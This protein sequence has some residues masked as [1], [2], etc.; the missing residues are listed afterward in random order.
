MANGNVYSV[1]HN[2]NV[3]GDLINV[4][5]ATAEEVKDHMI[6]LAEVSDELFEAVISVK[7]A[8]LAKGVFSERSSNGS[9]SATPPTATTTAVSS[10][11]DG[12]KSCKHGEL[13][14]LDYVKTDGTPVKGWYCQAK[15]TGKGSKCDPIRL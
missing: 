3:G 11:P 4:N 8:A 1:Q 10:N 15:W 2:L 14:F 6:A 7:Q 5:G 13:K 12:T 9:Q